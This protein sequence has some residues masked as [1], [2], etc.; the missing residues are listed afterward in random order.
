[1]AEFEDRYGQPALDRFRTGKAYTVSQAARL[2]KTTPQTVRRWLL[3]YDAAGHRMVPVF[4]NKQQQF[5]EAGFLV[6]FLELIEV[7]VVARFRHGLASGHPVPL[8]RLRQAHAYARRAFDL[9]YPFASLN[10]RESGG[11]ILH[12]FDEHNPDGPRL[13][14]DLQGQW[15]LPGIVRS[16]LQQMDFDTDHPQQDPFAL[17]WFPQGRSVPIVVDPHIAAGRPTIYRRGITVETIAQRFHHGE[18]VQDIADD[19]E[20]GRDLVEEALRYAA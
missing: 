16:E 1:M 12:Q 9:P 10:L 15:E 20:I 6:S 7:V 17:R 13:A 19:Y 11:H 8:D 3:G 4:G 2:A 14:L 5:Q 18:S